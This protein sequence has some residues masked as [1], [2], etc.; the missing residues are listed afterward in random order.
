MKM[1][2]YIFISIQDKTG[3][4]KLK[5]EWDKNDQEARN[6]AQEEF[7]RL[8]ES[9]YR[10]FEVKKILGII[11]TK[12]KEIKEYDPKGGIVY[13]EK[14]IDRGF[15]AKEAEVDIIRYQESKLFNPETD[16]VTTDKSYVLTKP[17][18]AG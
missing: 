10:I 14:D 8:Q 11:K 9:G 1:E 15:S 18:K 5:L 2:N 4:S 7:K 3:D 6:F 12:G 17:L 13:Y 16:E